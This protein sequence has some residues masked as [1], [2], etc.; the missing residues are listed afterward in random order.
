[1]ELFTDLKSIGLSNILK[2]DTL[3]IDEITIVHIDDFEK[4]YEQF[5]EDLMFHRN[6]YVADVFHH[7]IIINFNKFRIKESQMIELYN[8][9]PDILQF[10]ISGIIFKFDKDLK[11]L[12]SNEIK[13]NNSELNYCFN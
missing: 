7:I 10:N 4:D 3:I 2:D 6:H 8:S 12:K 11:L 9:L 5:T 13:L 1:M